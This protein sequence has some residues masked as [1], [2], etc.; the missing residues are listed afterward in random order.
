MNHRLAFYDKEDRPWLGLRLTS[1]AIVGHTTETST[2]LWFRVHTP[3]DFYL[4]VTT[5][6]IDVSL[7][8]RVDDY[9]G[10]LVLES[11]DS[12]KPIPGLI[13]SERQR[14]GFHS[15]CTHVFD[16]D[17]LEPGTTYHYALFALN[18]SRRE[19]WEVG[20]D[21]PHTFRTQSRGDSLSFGFFSCHMPF[22]SDEVRN[23]HMW[24]HL[25]QVLAQQGAAFLIG[26]GDQVYSDGDSKVDIWRWLRKNKDEVWDLL[27]RDR[28]QCL[29]VMKSWYRDIYRGYWG[30][31]ALRRVFRQTP[32]YM[33]WDD[34]EIMDGW[35]S[36][37]QDELSD[38][39]DSIWEWE[40]RKQNLTLARAMREAAITVYEE[41]QDSHNPRRD[42]KGWDYT[43]RCGPAAFFAFDMRGA[44]DY[45]AEEQRL[46]GP[47]QWERFKDWINRETLSDSKVLFVVSPVPVLHLSEFIANT[48]DL[49]LLGLA[50][51][52]R[53]EWEHKSNHAERDEL[54]SLVFDRAHQSGKRVV[55]LSGDVHVSAAFRLSRAGQRRARVYQLT[56]SGITYCKAPGALLRLAVRNRGHLG[57]AK[58]QPK[59]SFERLQEVFTDNNFATIHLEPDRNDLSGIRVAWDLYGDSGEP[60][61]VQRLRRLEI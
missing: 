8:P 35:G 53:D 10:G 32:T 13:Y 45:E 18:K 11:E 22:K 17:D 14:F 21:E 41:Y 38:L 29:E 36:Y 2:R 39:L 34:H 33:I 12:S 52:L 47:Q 54:L 55:F 44:H 3:G 26:G 9:S 24:S 59:I 5:E 15:D 37:T 4:I 19:A 60:G 30:Y 31:L 28:S 48:L 40:N 51:D 56:S 23:M 16:V 61:R 1:A 7:R 20:R 27:R 42:H 50:D 25:G 46:L 49:T 57:V 58:G 6:R 43:W